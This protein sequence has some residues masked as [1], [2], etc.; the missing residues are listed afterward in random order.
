MSFL[1]IEKVLWAVVAAL[2]FATL[3]TVPRRAFWAVAVLAAIGYALRGFALDNG[4]SL[5]LATL[6]GS[7]VMGLLSIQLAHWVHT[8][9]TVFMAPAVI[10]MVPGLYAYRF[11]MGLLEIS[12]NPDVP[13]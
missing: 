5:V 10:P 6:L 9:T 8:P 3:F 4:A 11:M 2:G 12:H 1:F 13:V 7:C